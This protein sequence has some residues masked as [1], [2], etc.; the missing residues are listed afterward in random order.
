[1]EHTFGP[2]VSSL[3]PGLKIDVGCFRVR[4]LVSHVFLLSS[5][6]AFFLLS[7]AAERSFGQL[8]L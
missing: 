7:L 4:F 2:D 6:E 3:L 8:L 1:M 5:R